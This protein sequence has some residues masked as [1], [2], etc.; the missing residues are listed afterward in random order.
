[1]NNTTKYLTAIAA[2]FLSVSTACQTAG[3]SNVDSTRTTN[4]SV[5]NTNTTT[6]TAIAPPAATSN[7]AGTPSEAY[8]AAFTARNNKDVPGLKKLMSKDIIEF[9]TMMGDSDEKKQTLDQILMKLCER[10]QAATAETR[11]E[12]INGDKATLEYLNEKG[13]WGPMDFIR[14]EGIWKLTIDEAT[15][16]TKDGN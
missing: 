5:T 15:A 7:T 11:N 12:K 3:N 16:A 9:F 10:P 2:V 14:E 6:N 1:M 4:I 13:G 8:K